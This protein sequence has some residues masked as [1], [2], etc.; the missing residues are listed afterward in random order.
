MCI[1]SKALTSLAEEEDQYTGNY[2]LVTH[3]MSD[4]WWNTIELPKLWDVQVPHQNVAQCDNQDHWQW[5]QTICLQIHAHHLLAVQSQA[6]HIISL[7][8]VSVK[9]ICKMQLFFCCC[10]YTLYINL[11][12][13]NFLLKTTQKKYKENIK[14]H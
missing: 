12:V 9:V 4:L 13:V 7:P 14:C 8:S 2:H 3:V 1:T 10:C 11:L 5:S 6:N